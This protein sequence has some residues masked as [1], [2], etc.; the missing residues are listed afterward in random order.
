MTEQHFVLKLFFKKKYKLIA[1]VWRQVY[2][3]LITICVLTKPVVSAPSSL[4]MFRSSLGFNRDNDTDGP[5]ASPHDDTDKTQ[6][7]K[8]LLD[9]VPPA[10]LRWRTPCA[11]SS[12][13]HGVDGLFDSV[14]TA[15]IAPHE[16]FSVIAL[17]AMEHHGKVISLMSKYV[18]VNL[19]FLLT[20]ACL[21]VQQKSV[22]VPF[23]SQN[24]ILY[25]NR[26]L[27]THSLLGTNSKRET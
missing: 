20:T 13:A 25:G 15:A 2:A 3:F 10:Q 23:H 5:E 18:S 17:K 9:D 6:W 7:R 27:T 12:P 16:H 14:E 19:H 22:G 11:G 24:C 4:E 21:V 1:D 26:K 8:S